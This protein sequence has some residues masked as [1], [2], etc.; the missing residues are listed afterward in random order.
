MQA[1]PI[2][3]NKTMRTRRSPRKAI[4]AVAGILALACSLFA[5]TGFLQPRAVAQTSTAP[6]LVVT[7]ITPQ[8]ADS[9]AGV[10]VALGGILLTNGTSPGQF[11][12][13]VTWTLT[14]VNSSLQTVTVES[15][16]FQTTIVE[17]LT[18][19]VYDFSFNIDTSNIS[20]GNYTLTVSVTALSPY[21]GK[22]SNTHGL[23]VQHPTPTGGT[24]T[25][26]SENSV[27][28]SDLVPSSW[29]FPV[30]PS[31]DPCSVA[32]C[33]GTSSTY[34][35]MPLG[36]YTLQPSSTIGSAAGMYVL[37]SV[38]LQPI[39]ERQGN[40]FLSLFEDLPGFLS[41]ARAEVV[42]G[43]VD[44]GASSCPNP[45]PSLDLANSGDTANFIILW[46]PMASIGVNP[47]AVSSTVTAS[48]AATMNATIQNSG[49]PGSTLDWSASTSS[50]P[51]W[52]T[53]S[54][55]SGCLD[56]GGVAANGC[57]DT[58]GSQT[59]TLTANSS[60]L[61][62]GTYT[63]TVTI[64]WNSLPSPLTNLS[65]KTI[66]VTFAVG[67][68]PPSVSLSA[69]PAS[70][71]SGGSSTLTWSSSGASSCAASASPSSAS[72]SGSEPLSGSQ[73]VSPAGT[74]AYSLSCTGTGGTTSQSATVTVGAASSPPNCT[75]GA[76][77]QQ[78]VPPEAST[79]SWSCTNVVSCTL[80][81]TAVGV[82]GNEQVS[83][84]ADTTYTLTCQ[85]SGSGSTNTVTAET[86][87]TTGGPN[88][89][90]VNP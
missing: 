55:T 21:S 53:V 39:A 67:A 32:A 28:T 85:G 46:D 75:F 65:P 8:P 86:T 58:S 47:T 19:D 68:V 90:E 29:Y 7:N 56:A 35:N 81:G 89:Q 73:S 34:P 66:A 44:S 38:E 69:S 61:A 80:D 4:Y 25:V 10:N 33:Q 36:P 22:W 78:I 3:R 52:L 30:Y 84:A 64:D 37:H 83:P 43:F 18:Q 20:N 40:L 31:A 76:N 6:N 54:P 2:L 62:T 48:A 23:W 9:Y 72:W 12:A 50:L 5:V 74:T 41:R 27:L 57:S 17:S 71:A 11:P 14:T 26:T 82:T 24:V 45:A 15:S 77:P 59:L 79:L 70:V 51:S 63:G 49:A 1:L 88:V 16:T 87:V 42:C 60:G 13:S